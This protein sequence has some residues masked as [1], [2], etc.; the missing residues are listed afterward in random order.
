MRLR[1]TEQMENKEQV[2]DGVQ[3]L[4]GCRVALGMGLVKM[5]LRPVLLVIRLI[6]GNRERER[7]REKLIC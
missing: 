1:A 6:S 7:E 3:M 2:F 5:L 4:G